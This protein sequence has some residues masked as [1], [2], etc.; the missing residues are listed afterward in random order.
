MAYKVKRSAKVEEEL[1]LTSADGKTTELIKVQ[2]D[3]SAVAEKVS[4]NYAELLRIQAKLTGKD[5]Q[6]DKA[7]LFE[8]LGNA[9]VVLFQTIFG[10]ENTE[11]IIRFYE[12]DYIDMCRTIMPFIRDVVV[13]QVR[14]EAQKS[15]KVRMQSYSRNKGFMRKR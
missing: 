11:R 13:P 14:S 3:A 8:E 15:R 6:E 4:R 10:E 5:N 1:E 12:K 2:L 7:Q 9:A